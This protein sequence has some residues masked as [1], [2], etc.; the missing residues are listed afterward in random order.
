[1]Q[2]QIKRRNMFLQFVLMVVTFGFYAIY[3][4]YQT[5]T[6]MKTITNDQT[7]Q[8]GLWTVLLFV[9]F[10]GL[11]SFY[12]YGELYEK[13]GDEKLNKWITFLLWLAIPMVVWILV[14]IDLNKKATNLLAGQSRAA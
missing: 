3:W 8:V 1:M 9:P 11:Y 14:Q 4:F 5:A 12:K 6:E 10:G 7:A 2:P 13:A